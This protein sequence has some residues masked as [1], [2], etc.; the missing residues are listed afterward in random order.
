MARCPL[1]HVL[2]SAWTRVALLQSTTLGVFRPLVTRALSHLGR[3]SLLAHSLA[4]LRGD[5]NGPQVL[6][7]CIVGLEQ[8]VFLRACT[9]GAFHDGTSG[10][11]D[12]AG[13]LYH[14]TRPFPLF[15][16]V[17]F[18]L[19]GPWG[20]CLKRTCVNHLVYFRFEK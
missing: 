12:E 20:Q 2:L 16:F 9:A 6:Q 1:A 14:L 13:R 18:C 17:P 4:Q 5:T 15:V 11:T 19:L 7:H 10:W 8:V 3:A